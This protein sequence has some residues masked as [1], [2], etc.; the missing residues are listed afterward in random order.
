VEHYFYSQIDVTLSAAKRPNSPVVPSGNGELHYLMR[1]MLSCQM[2]QNELLEEL[3]D[4]VSSGQRRRM[5][6]LAVW[7][8]ANPQ[9]SRFCKTAADRLGKVQTEFLHSITVEIH[10]NFEEM[11]DGEYALQEFVDR[12]GPRFMHLTGLLQIL[13][14]LGNAP[15]VP[16]SPPVAPFVR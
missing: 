14:Q 9:L 8:N 11:A 16:H 12:F 3:V 2:R 6:E 1:E 15:E 5:A 10:D 4:Q 13:T 7:K